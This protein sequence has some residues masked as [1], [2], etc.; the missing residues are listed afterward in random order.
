M[1]TDTAGT[2]REPGISLM[3]ALVAIIESSPPVPANEG[4]QP[5]VER[6]RATPGEEIP[7]E[8]SAAD[9]P[10]SQRRPRDERLPEQGARLRV[11]VRELGI[12]REQ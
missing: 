10:K 6:G 8:D 11:H 9:G 1:I 5:A 7:K 4:L 3:A 12:A 2:L